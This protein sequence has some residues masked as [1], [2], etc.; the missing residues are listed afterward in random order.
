MSSMIKMK[1]V[2][3]HGGRHGAKSTL[4]RMPP[5]AVTPHGIRWDFLTKLQMKRLKRH[6]CAVEGCDCT[7]KEWKYYEE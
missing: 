6:M 3:V 1:R 7:P 5:S 4:V 2:W